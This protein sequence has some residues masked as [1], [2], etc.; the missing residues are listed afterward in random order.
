MTIKHFHRQR[1]IGNS[2]DEDAQ[3]EQEEEELGDGRQ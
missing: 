1:V 3:V 2:L